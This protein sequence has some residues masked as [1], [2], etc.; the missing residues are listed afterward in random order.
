MC[1]IHRQTCFVQSE[2]FSV[3]RQARFPKLG[4]K[5][6]WLKRQPKILPLNHEE[7]SRGSFDKNRRILP[8][9]L[10]I[11]TTVYS[12]TFFEELIR[13]SFFSI[14]RDSAWPFLLLLPEHFRYWRVTSF[15]HHR[16]FLKLRLRVANKCLAHLLTCFTRL[17]QYTH[18]ICFF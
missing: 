3:V 18:L 14:P 9:E 6:G 16:L 5:P 8:R 1:V 10:A 13:D 12:Y 17:F 2:L 15:P 7:T 11:E 4:S